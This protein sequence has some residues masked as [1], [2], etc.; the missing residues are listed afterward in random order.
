MSLPLMD[1]G[2]MPWAKDQWAHNV[3]SKKSELTQRLN[4]EKGFPLDGRRGRVVKWNLQC[5]TR[6][7]RGYVLRRCHNNALFCGRWKAQW[8]GSYWIQAARGH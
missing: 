3:S 2:R 6:G 7:K 4:S 5:Y 1:H 8:A